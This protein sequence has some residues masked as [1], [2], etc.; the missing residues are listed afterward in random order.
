VSQ[1]LVEIC[2]RTTYATIVYLHRKIGE[3]SVAIQFLKM[4]WKETI[5]YENIQ[6]NSPRTLCEGPRIRE[7]YRNMHSWS[8][9][10]RFLT[11]IKVNRN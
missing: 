3:T 7:K 8:L 10:T 5:Y 1:E 4:F 11:A 6:G 2:S 9:L